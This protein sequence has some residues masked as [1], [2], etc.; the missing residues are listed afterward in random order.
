M[1]CFASLV[2]TYAALQVEPTAL[3]LR[4]D[5]N[6]KQ[7]INVLISSVCPEVFYVE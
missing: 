7:L 6:T 2:K 4:D 3:N 5:S 1:S